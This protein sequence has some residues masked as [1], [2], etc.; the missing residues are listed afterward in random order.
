[1]KRAWTVAA[2]AVAAVALALAG[3]GGG[4]TSPASP[5]PGDG[6]TLRATWT[7]PDGD[8]TPQRTPGEPLRD[9]TDLAP[10]ARAGRVVGSLGILTD[11]HVRDEESPARVPFLDRLG[12]PFSSTFRPQDPLSV[13]VLVAA[14]RALDD[15]RPDTALV[16]G[17]LVDNAQRNGVAW[18]SRALRGGVVRP[19]SGAGGY[20]GPQEASNPDPAFYRPDV[21][22]PRLPG[23]LAR[24]QAP[25]RSP[26]LAMPLRVLPGNHDL[27]LAGEVRRTGRTEAVATGDRLLVEPDEDLQ[28]LGR[29]EEALRGDTIDRVLRDGLPG[30]TRAV[31]P[32]PARSELTPAGATTALRALGG[33]AP[34][35]ARLDQAFDIGPRVRVVALDTVSRAFGAGGE[36]TAAQVAWLRRELRRAGDRWV[37]VAS[38]HALTK[39]RGGRAAL[40]LLDRD[41]RVLA[42]LNG[43]GH[44]HRIVPRPTPAG[45]FWLVGTA[46]LADWPQQGRMLRVRETAGGGAV[47]ETWALDTAP[48]PLADD[49]RLLA[50]LDAQGG[51]PSGERGTVLD[52]NVRLFKGAPG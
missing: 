14:V 24:A 20:E 6:S 31:A 37:I 47:L 50:H 34:S 9:R 8:G 42:A 13:Q 36:V 17:D 19:D 40:R 1:M 7:D 26:G 25:V 30:R 15:A 33:L 10:A 4:A 35:A 51:R 27:L 5:G 28:R 11:V 22:P 2:P 32:D 41:P 29:T 12:A 16:L 23:L 44:R 45:G 52:R 3:C 48:D 46:S 43:D 18:A 39:V 21:D 38:H 49:A